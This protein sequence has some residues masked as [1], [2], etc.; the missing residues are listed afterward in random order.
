MTPSDAQREAAGQVRQTVWVNPGSMRH[1]QH[2]ELPWPPPDDCQAFPMPGP[3]EFAGDQPHWHGNTDVQG[4][5]IPSDEQLLAEELA[6]GVKHGRLEAPP[7]GGAGILDGS[8]YRLLSQAEALEL[9]VNTAKGQT[10]GEQTTEDGRFQ[11]HPLYQAF[12]EAWRQATSGKGQRHGG[13]ATP[14][15]AQSWRHI[16]DAQGPGFLVGQAEKKLHEAGAR[17]RQAATP[18]DGRHS[19]SLASPADLGDASAHVHSFTGNAPPWPGDEAWQRE[20]LG[21]LVYGGMA[22]LHATGRVAKE[23]GH[24]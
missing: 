15:Y 16:A 8:G 10:L 23:G 7:P 20:V 18:P 1:L 4:H 11:Q 9:V 19:Q 21:A 6:A 14:F 12:K 2:D 24:G 13:D 3:G 5:R 17:V 22:W